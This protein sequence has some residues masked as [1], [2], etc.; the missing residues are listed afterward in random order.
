MRVVLA[1]GPMTDALGR[2]ALARTTI[3][4]S[5]LEIELA[6]TSA[7]AAEFSISLYHEVLEAAAVAALH[8]P[9]AVCE[10]NEA[11]F[12]AAA[13]DCHQRLGPAS[14]SFSIECWGN[15]CF[16]SSFRRESHS[17][18]TTA[19]SHGRQPNSPA[20]GRSHGADFSRDALN[21]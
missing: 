17:P 16:H 2:V 10:L 12:E 6:G 7:E 18:L 20:G 8:P 14:L 19:H 15:S 11:G 5:N 4:G 21:L 13:L 1:S 3:T 9:P